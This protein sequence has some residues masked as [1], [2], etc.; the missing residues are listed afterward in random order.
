MPY[1]SLDESGVVIGVYA[2]P[3]RVFQQALTYHSTGRLKERLAEYPKLLEEA[4]A[5]GEDVDATTDWLLA[6]WPQEHDDPQIG[7]RLSDVSDDDPPWAADDDP[8]HPVTFEQLPDDDFGTEMLAAEGETT[9]YPGALIDQRRNDI[10]LRIDDIARTRAQ[11]ANDVLTGTDIQAITQKIML[12]IASDDDR[13]TERLFYAARTL[14]ERIAAFAES[15]KR[16]LR[17]MS[18]P[19]L[20][21]FDPA[22]VSWPA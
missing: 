19:Q 6:N 16:S 3:R 21:A 11:A 7:Q 15:M 4:A 13:T 8:E 17:D 14:S 12:G 22:A 2:Q 9:A 20:D 10:S 18:G 5:R 1:V